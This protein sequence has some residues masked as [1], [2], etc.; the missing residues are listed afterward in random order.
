MLRQI[1]KARADLYGIS[2]D[3]IQ[4]QLAAAYTWVTREDGAA[5]ATYLLKGPLARTF[6]ETHAAGA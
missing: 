6:N 1:D 5:D 3:R 4:V 2:E